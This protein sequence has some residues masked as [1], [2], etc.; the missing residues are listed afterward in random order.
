MIGRPRRMLIAIIIAVVVAAAFL[1]A[2]IKTVAAQA[3]SGIGYGVQVSRAVWSNNG[4]ALS[5]VGLRICGE[6]GTP[7]PPPYPSPS[8]SPKPKQRA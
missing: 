5:I 1:P 4:A 7:L 8:P 2:G 6:D 3:R